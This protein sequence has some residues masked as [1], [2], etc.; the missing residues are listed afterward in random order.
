LGKTSDA[1]VA[2]ASVPMVAAARQTKDM[3]DEVAGD[4]AQ[5]TNGGR[6][7]VELANVNVCVSIL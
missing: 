1:S 7:K 6:H 3:P 4:H 5:K 2:A